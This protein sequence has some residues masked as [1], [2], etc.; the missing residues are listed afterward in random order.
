MSTVSQPCIRKCC[1][2]E[3]DVCLGCFRTF[4]DMLLWQ[5][6]T[7]SEKVQMLAHAQ[8][9]KCKERKRIVEI[10]HMKANKE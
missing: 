5:K 10:K 9:R 3:E 1:L 2:N 7:H 6:S 8:E 4:D